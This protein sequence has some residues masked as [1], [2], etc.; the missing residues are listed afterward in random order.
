MRFL[1]I[2]IPCFFIQAI[3]C[4]QSGLDVELGVDRWKI[5]TAADKLSETSK[6]KHIPLEKLLRLP[7][8][9]PEY[10]KGD[11]D[12][13]LIPQSPGLKLNEGDIIT[14]EGYMHLVAL[15][16]ASDTHKDGDYHIQITLNP[17]W[18]DSCF[19]VEIPYKAFIKNKDLKDL[20]DKNRQFIRKR[21][22]KDESKEP[23]AGGNV[24]KG[25][26]YVRVTG[27]LFYD[28]IHSSTMRNKNPK[29]NKYRGKKGKSDTPMHSYT[30]WEIHP[31]TD[32][33]FWPK[34]K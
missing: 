9:A 25:I 3:V 1:T 18:T 34:P 4:A 19:I 21:I 10:S 26:V 15:E 22:L 27:Q 2:L 32:I 20:C 12:E 28:A 31:V 29:K 13:V 24:M 14:T 16:R 17:E 23:S 5:K 33:V 11:Y 8:L 7:L 30:A 6:S